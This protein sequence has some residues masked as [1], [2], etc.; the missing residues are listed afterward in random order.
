MVVDT[1]QGEHAIASCGE[2]A[3]CQGCGL[4]GEVEGGKVD[5][6]DGCFYCFRCWQAYELEGAEFGEALGEDGGAAGYGRWQ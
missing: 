4:V 2:E 5:H 3:E 6:G 1:W